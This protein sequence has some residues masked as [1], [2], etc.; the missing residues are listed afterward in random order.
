[1]KIWIGNWVY[2]V[3]GFEKGIWQL[4]F[5]EST[6]TTFTLKAYCSSYFIQKVSANQFTGNLYYLLKYKSHKGYFDWENDV[7]LWKFDKKSQHFIAKSVTK[8]FKLWT[9]NSESIF[10]DKILHFEKQ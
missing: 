3:L 7:K 9:K 2:Q 1:M 6:S 4:D 10:S 5:I 8:S